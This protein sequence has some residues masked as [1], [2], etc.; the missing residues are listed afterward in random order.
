[1]ASMRIFRWR[2]ALELAKCARVSS[3]LTKL[4][5]SRT[6]STCLQRPMLRVGQQQM[7]K[8][9]SV[10]T[11][12]SDQKLSQAQVEEKVLSLFENFD[13]IKEN[14]AKPK[15]TL[16]SHVAKD[17]SLDSLDH[18][19]IIVQLEDTFGKANFSQNLN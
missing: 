11:Y 9:A 12:A 6:F 2:Q 18:V 17:L 8:L 14:P 15:V 4:P 5:T 3:Q 7:L 16:D 1:M 19:E 13:R 10:R